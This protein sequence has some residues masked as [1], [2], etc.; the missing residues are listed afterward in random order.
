MKRQKAPQA[1]DRFKESTFQAEAEYAESMFRS[2]LGGIEASVA[3]L[4]RSL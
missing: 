4:K 2:A 1:K 3:A